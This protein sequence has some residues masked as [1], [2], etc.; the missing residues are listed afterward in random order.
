MIFWTKVNR[1]YFMCLKLIA[2]SKA[3]QAIIWGLLF[4]FLV[5]SLP[6][7]LLAIKQLLH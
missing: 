3:L 1:W 5:K 7:L 6:P 4:I 2:K